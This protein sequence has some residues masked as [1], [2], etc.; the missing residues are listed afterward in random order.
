MLSAYFGLAANTLMCCANVSC[1]CITC[2]I[3]TPQV[4]YPEHNIYI[5]IYLMA[6]TSSGIW[7]YLTALG[8]N[9]SNYRTSTSVVSGGPSTLGLVHVWMVPSSVEYPQ[10]THYDQDMLYHGPLNSSVTHSK[11]WQPLKLSLASYL[12][13]CSWAPNPL[14]TLLGQMYY[15]VHPLTDQGLGI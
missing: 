6:I 2:L 1:W 8:C 4:L 10:S 12:E 13:A 15:S 7:F 5:Y 3:S 9:F 14:W 11:S